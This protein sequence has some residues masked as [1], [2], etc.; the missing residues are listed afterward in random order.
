MKTIDI[1]TTQN[2][3]IEYELATLRE[4]ILAFFIDFVIVYVSFSI[5]FFVL[6]A[7]FTDVFLGIDN[8]ALTAVV[9]FSFFVFY[10][11]FSEII[12]DGQSWG[13]KAVGI[14]VVRLDGFF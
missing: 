3:T 10:Q 4:R 6:K 1:R 12:A 2:V 9:L 7:G 14:K 8:Y 11:L 13:K 5:L